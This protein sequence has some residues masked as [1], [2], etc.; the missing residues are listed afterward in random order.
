MAEM[1]LRTARPASIASLLNPVGLA[2]NL[3]SRRDLIVQF[4]QRYF[5][6][7]HRGTYLGMV[8]ALLFPLVLLAVYSFIFN[9]VFTARATRMVPDGVGGES[10]E[11]RMQY[12]VA[13]FLSLTIFNIFS[14]SVVRSTGLVLDNPNYVKRVVFP[15]EVLPVSSLGAALMFSLFGIGLSLAGAAVFYPKLYW[16]ALLL[17][18]VLTPMLALALGLAWFFSS[19]A[20]FVR[21]IGNLVAIVVGQI[22]FFMTP[23]F[24]R[25]EDLQEWAWIVGINPVGVVIE[26]ARQVTLYGEMPDWSALGGVLVIGLVVMQLGYT[27]FM[28]SKRGFADVL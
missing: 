6:A 23:I 10:P 9:F 12:A 3:W 7:R 13:L 17:P 14:E 25:A 1:V 16:T 19:L 15:L 22:L 18:V 2:A 5:L 20:V 24:Y 4:S 21:D 11:T 8:W 26:S 28:K 27:W